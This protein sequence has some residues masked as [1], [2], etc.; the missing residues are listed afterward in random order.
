[1]ETLACSYVPLHAVVT[2]CGEPHNVYFILDTTQSFDVDRA[3]PAIRALQLLKGALDNEATGIDMGVVLY[4]YIY[5]APRIFAP[6]T[7]KESK[8]V[9]GLDTECEEAAVKL[10]D[11]ARS[12]SWDQSEDTASFTALEYLKKNMDDTKPTDVIT[13]ASSFSGGYI[14]PSSSNYP[15]TK[16]GAAIDG[17]LSTSSY[18]MRF[19][20]IGDRGKRQ[21]EEYFTKELMALSDNKPSRIVEMGVDES[22]VKFVSSIVDVLENGN[23][24]CS[25]QGENATLT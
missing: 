5:T 10:D 18:P 1:M 8:F 4:P 21:N 24:V 15:P 19:F 23:I 20:A 16:I 22:S 14:D 12:L 25:D 6:R 3:Y 13:I 11:L 17:I 9:V 2:H 7:N